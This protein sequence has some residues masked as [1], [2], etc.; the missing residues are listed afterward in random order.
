MDLLSQHI[1]REIKALRPS[2]SGEL[3]QWRRYADEV[4]RLSPVVVQEALDALHKAVAM[5]LRL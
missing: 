5:Q 1:Q 2:N 3:E 4:E